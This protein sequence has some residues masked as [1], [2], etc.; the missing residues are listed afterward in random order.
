MLTPIQKPT[1]TRNLNLS[2]LKIEFMSARRIKI[3]IIRYALS[4]GIIEAFAEID[5]EGWAKCIASPSL[6]V[7]YVSDFPKSDYRT[8]YKEAC[9]AAYAKRDKKVASLKKQIETLK[10]LTFV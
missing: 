9:L 1:T 5:N 3:W 8:S 2:S 7:I 10:K 4:E 6:T